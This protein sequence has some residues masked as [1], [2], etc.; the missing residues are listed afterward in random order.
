MP[1]LLST[2][3]LS[4]VWQREPDTRGALSKPASLSLSVLTQGR[5]KEVTA[6]FRKVMR[7]P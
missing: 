1:F 3:I 5:G 7:I 2:A 6:P 4:L